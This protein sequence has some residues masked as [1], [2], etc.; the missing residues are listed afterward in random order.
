[1]TDDMGPRWTLTYR[2]AG[3]DETT[4]TLTLVI[5]AESMVT[6]IKEAQIKL[7]EPV[8]GEPPPLYRIVSITPA[9]T[10]EVCGTAFD[11]NEALRLHRV[12][13]TAREAAGHPHLPGASS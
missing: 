7:R 10:C 2:L 13:A 1:M 6:A 12:A 8:D 3:I 4:P 11:T 9:P 5:A